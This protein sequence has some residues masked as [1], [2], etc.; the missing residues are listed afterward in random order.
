MQETPYKIRQILKRR[1]SGVTE[2]SYCTLDAILKFDG[3]ESPHCVYIEHVALRLAQ[4]FHIPVADGALTMAGDG[5]AYASLE[6]ATP[7]I[8]LPNVL[9]SQCERIA[10]TY[11]NEVAA[12]T[13]FDILIGNWDR[14]RNLKAS[15]VTPHIRLFKAFDHSHALLNIKESPRDS[16]ALL[17][18]ND[19]ILRFHPFFGHVSG[20]LLEE[21][22]DR[23]AAVEDIYIK[24]C[25]CFGR[26]F[27]AVDEQL[28]SGLAKA[29]S[30]RKNTLKAILAANIG[31]IRPIL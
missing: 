18:S 22:M 2:A 23:M 11:P 17:D 19:L 30:R 12:L 25:C 29:L 9:E 21:W 10:R 31:T 26:P 24:E 7:G 1:P 13:A 4:T 15:I 14:K 20:S 8:P 16:I 6:V 3:P 27:R 28:Q 5:P